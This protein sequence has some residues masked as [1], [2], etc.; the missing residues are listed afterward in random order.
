M[1]RFPDRTVALQ[2]CG[3]STLAWT[4]ALTLVTGA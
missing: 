3:V 1:W 4:E 2:V